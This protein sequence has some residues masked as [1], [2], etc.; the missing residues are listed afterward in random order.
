MLPQMMPLP[1]VM[2]FFLIVF[3]L[4]LLYIFFSFSF[5]YS[6]NLGC[7]VYFNRVKFSW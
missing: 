3:F 6:D 1:W 4:F 7:K 5:L 2:I